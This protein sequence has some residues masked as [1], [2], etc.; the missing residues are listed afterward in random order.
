VLSSASLTTSTFSS[1]IIH[2][3]FVTK[4]HTSALL[5]AALASLASAEV[6]HP[7]QPRAVTN[8]ALQTTF[9]SPSGTTNLA[10]AKTIA[11]GASFDGGMKQWDRSGTHITT[12]D[13]P[14]K[15]DNR[16]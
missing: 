15:P 5:V 1:P 12:D 4:M 13:A 3:N 16:V 6:K 10:A 11:A 8:T 14:C 2:R 7:H 9:P